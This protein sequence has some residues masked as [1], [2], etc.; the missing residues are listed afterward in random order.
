MPVLRLKVRRGVLIL[1]TNVAIMRR[2]DPFKKAQKFFG[3]ER[4]LQGAKLAM[5]PAERHLKIIEILKQREVVSVKEL[6]SLLR[7]S[8][9]T[10]RRDLK[11]LDGLVERRHGGAV[12][13]QDQT[14]T[15]FESSYEVRSITNLAEKRLI[16][17]HA[18]QL[19][20]NNCSLILD[21][22]STVL[23]LAKHL[24]SKKHL[25]LVTNDLLIALEF[26]DS[27]DHHVHLIGGELRK[28]SYSLIGPQA[29]EFLQ[30]LSVDV[31]FLGAHAINEKGISDTDMV[32]VYTKQAMIRAAKEV[33]VL[34]D[35]TKFGAHAFVQVCS[36]NHVD[37]IITDNNVDPGYCHNLEEIG[38]VEIIRCQTQL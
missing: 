14:S 10:I 21:S 6:S 33:L 26:A 36:L 24:K 3:N 32:H 25:T 37:K 31:A 13:R 8:P 17:Y 5:I 2:S 12:L 11:Q 9:V 18:A 30:K 27:R 19:V 23:Q 29:I 16:G 4:K 15:T 7:V 38:N 34:A 20:Q 1:D 28:G 22:S 35:H